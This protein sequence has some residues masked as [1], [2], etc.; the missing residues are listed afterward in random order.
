LPRDFTVGGATGDLFFWDGQGSASFVPAVASFRI[1]GGDPLGSVA[2]AG[3]A[4]DDHPFLTVDS[5]AL[6][7]IYLASAVGVVAGFAPSDP[8][9]FVMGSEDLIT[10]DF[11]GLTPAEF[12][13]LTDDE[14]DE[15]L[16][17]V[18]EQGMA[19]VE[20]HVVPE[21]STLVLVGNAALVA[22]RSVRRPANPRRAKFAR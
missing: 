11:L 4:F 2:G 3:G 22:L 20:A 15:A 6:P 18:I 7:G 21:P 16:E 14:L 1:D 19:Y 8:V 5:D 12:D 9:Y 17:G 10:A 13:M